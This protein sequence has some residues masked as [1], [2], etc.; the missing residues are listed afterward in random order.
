M[1]SYSNLYPGAGYGFE[2]KYSEFLGMEYRTQPS[3]LAITTD[4]RTANQIKEVGQKLNLGVTSIE[5]QALQ[6]NVAEAIPNQHFEE[7]N[8]LKKLVGVDLTLHG[9]LVEPTGV[10][11]QGWDE[12]Q[13]MQAERQMW[14]TLEKSHKLSPEGNLVVTFHSSQGLPEPETRVFNEKTKKEEVREM[15]VVDERNGQFT[16]IVPKENYLTGEKADPYKELDE[17]NKRAWETNLSQIS[18]HSMQ[19]K[20]AID[21][22]LN[23]NRKIIEKDGESTKALMKKYWEMSKTEEGQKYLENNIKSDVVKKEV[24]RA[25]DHL[26]YGEI[27][28]K[29]AYINL[30]EHFNKAWTAT[31]KTIQ[32][33]KNEAER[34]KAEEDFNKLKKFQQEI[35][36]KKDK[37]FSGFNA[38]ELANEV[39]KGVNVLNSLSAAPETF[40]PLREFAID[41]A[42]ETFSNLAIKSYDKFKETSPVISIENPPVGM[43]LCRGEDIKALVEETRKRFAKK[44]EKELGLSKKQAEEQAEKLIG[45]TWDLGHINMVRKYGYGE[46]YLKEQTKAVGKLIKNVHLSDN[47]G[48][49][50]T[51][52]PM[53]MG[54]VPTKAHMDIINEYNKKVKK[55]IETGD[56]YQHMQTSPL[57]ETLAAF[58]SPLYAMQMG[59]YWSQIQGNM[60][61]YF[62]GFGYNPEI[63]HSMYGAGF[64]NLPIELGGQMAGK[65]RLAGAPME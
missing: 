31:Q 15:M 51:E 62:A 35:V 6:P 58:G 32:A 11:K 57:G 12:T 46:D 40:R 37:L 5:V 65:N 3:E 21:A 42:S 17:Q 49:E 8:R 20:E 52:L 56:W 25:I 47:F 2:P 28:A 55:V 54:N 22:G 26:N 61:G 27:Y 45:A 23:L 41:K 7:I 53:G 43:G 38:E 16:P 1:A 64:A 44:A 4:A 36:S 24:E 30:Q 29:E 10:T 48:M 18:F 59:P 63:H 19:G 50:H 9:P 33:A 60:G 14:V 34:K 39:Q 13:R